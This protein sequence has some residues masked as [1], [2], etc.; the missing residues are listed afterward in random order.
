MIIDIIKEVDIH[1]LSVG[2]SFIMFAYIIIT[3]KNK[4]RQ[5]NAFFFLVIATMLTIFIEMLAILMTPDQYYFAYWFNVIAYIGSPVIAYS[6]AVYIFSI[7]NKSRKKFVTFMIIASI[8]AIINSILLVLNPITHKH[9]TL[10]ADL[11]FT[12]GPF[13]YILAGAAGLY[14]LIAL[15]LIVINRSELG[16]VNTRKLLAFTA[17][18]IIGATLQVL[19]YGIYALWICLA[20]AIMAVYLNIQNTELSIDY[21]TKVNNHR[22]LVQFLESKIESKSRRSFSAFMMDI[23][24]F[25]SINDTFGHD[26]G[27]RALKDIANM[28]KSLFGNR[29]FICRFGGDEFV[30]VMNDITSQQAVIETIDQALDLYNAMN[31][32]YTL[33][34]S[35]GTYDCDTSSGIT[36]D[37]LLKILDER[38]Y[39]AKRNKAFSRRASDV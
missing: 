28:L 32:D 19:F 23:D 36:C 26:V 8:P 33:S 10:D 25:K 15:I 12:R 34:L 31:D 4:T 6:W 13:F 7:S 14:M 27:D 5:Q 30:V 1:I 21:L 3:G 20:F 39:E 37:G 2:L 38:M 24:W 35:I 9:F 22:A 18:P 29:G 11:V 17:L 16:R